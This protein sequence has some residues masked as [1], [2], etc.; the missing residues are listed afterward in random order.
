MGLRGAGRLAPPPVVW[1]RSRVWLPSAAEAEALDRAARELHGI[2]ARVLMENAGRS[3]ALLVQLLY[4]AGPV[5]AAVGSGNNG[6]DALVL[7]RNLRAWGREVAWVQAGSEA[8]A[9]AV[10]HSFELPR[11][12]FSDAAFASAS[13]LV[14]GI[15]GTGSRG[16]PRGRAPAAIEALNRSGRPVVALDLPSGVDPDRGELPGQTEGASPEAVAVRADLT[17]CFGWPKR[18]LLRPPG[19]SHCGRLLAIEIG[20]PPVRDVAGAEAITPAWALARLPP[21][22][23]GAHKYEVGSLLVCAGRLDMAGAAVLAARSAVR[24]GTGLVRVISAQENRSVIQEAVPDALFVPRED[25]RAVREAARGSD[26][27]LAGPGMGTSVADGELLGWLFEET[28]DLPTVL[29]ADALTL[30]GGDGDLRAAA[31]ARP[32]VL[33]PHPGEFGRLWSGGSEAARGDPVL[34]AREF[35]D[36]NGGTLLLK[37]SPSVV[38]TAGQPVRIDAGASSDF[39]KAGMGD[40]LAGLTGG[41]LA[42]GAAP[43]DAA[44]AALG[45]SALA[46]AQLNYARALSPADLAEEVARIVAGPAPESYDPPFPFVVFDQPPPR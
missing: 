10:G 35:V 36:R 40:H 37:G 23:Y 14:D 12:D 39:A 1:G 13:V 43:A 20:F 17:I 46:A 11:V 3:A 7:L 45:L 38:A 22:R 30:I 8:P 9:S 26:A 44:A 19:R 27:L 24:A 28:G 21:R 18:G 33:T 15:L 5:V 4:P 32:L 6:G 25:E 34:A 16:A 31:F 2:P 42:Q 29:D 41:L